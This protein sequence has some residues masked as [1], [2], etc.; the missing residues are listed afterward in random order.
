MNLRRDVHAL[1]VPYALYALEP[2]ELR[3]FDRHLGRCAPCAAELRTLQAGTVR[4][5]CAAAATAPAGLRARVLAAAR[6]TEQEPVRAAR[7]IRQESAP[8][9]RTIRQESAP[10]VRTTRQDALP[11]R[12]IQQESAPDAPDAPDTPD[13][14]DAPAPRRPRGR[15]PAAAVAFLTASA[16]ALALLA[17][18]LLGVQ[19]QQARSRLADD[20]AQAQG[21]ARVLAA[22][23]AHAGSGR[24]RGGAAVSVLASPALDRA[25]VIVTGVAGPPRGKVHQLWQTGHGRARSLGLLDG[26]RP[27]LA[28]G[29]DARS[30]GLAVTEEPDG[31]SPRPTTA[32]LVQV[33]LESGV[34][35]E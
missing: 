28:R 21:I 2:R 17:A 11:V 8:A 5:A 6:T 9:A 25:V 31:G 1:A 22:P 34:F 23:D 30:T 27:L 12:A 20:R 32:P 16:A 29:L 24:G 19:L 26:E 7:S 10:A 4:L 14:P 3:R 18:V 33:A 35:G 15:S 13:A